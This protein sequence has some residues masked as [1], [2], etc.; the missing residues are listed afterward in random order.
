MA[1]TMGADPPVELG[2]QPI[3]IGVVIQGAQ[4]FDEFL[5]TA[6]GQKS[7]KVRRAID[8]GI[9]SKSG[10]DRSKDFVPVHSRTNAAAKSEFL[11][12]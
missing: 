6:S 12:K 5:L 3:E 8:N 2:A 9:A 10:P 4:V 7:E 1:L 11:Q